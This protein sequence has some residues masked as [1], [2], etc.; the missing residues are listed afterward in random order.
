MKKIVIFTL[1]FFIFS[2]AFSYTNTTAKNVNFSQQELDFNNSEIEKAFK[3]FFDP[4]AETGRDFFDEYIKLDYD[5]LSPK[6]KESADSIIKTANDYS[7]LLLKNM[8]YEI[9]SITYTG[10][11]TAVVEINITSPEITDYLNENKLKIME[12]TVAMIEARTGKSIAQIAK[13][14]A[15]N[16]EY[17]QIISISTSEALLNFYIEG[18][19]ESTKDVTETK[20]FNVEKTDTTWIIKSDIYSI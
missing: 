8:K 3:I 5:K 17:P 12:S 14:R 2:M 13:E 6:V 18:I 19:K 15:S 20:K 11:K 9:S 4:A 10:P 16:K 1:F 7:T